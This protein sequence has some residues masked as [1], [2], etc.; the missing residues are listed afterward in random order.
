MSSL[1]ALALRIP[2]LLVQGQTPLFKV[3]S[4]IQGAKLS[5]SSPTPN[6]AKAFFVIVADLCHCDPSEQGNGLAA[7]EVLPRVPDEGRAQPWSTPATPGLLREPQLHHLQPGLRHSSTSGL[8]DAWGMTCTEKQQNSFKTCSLLNLLIILLWE[9]DAICTSLLQT[10]SL[11]PEIWAHTGATGTSPCRNGT[12]PPAHTTD[13][14]TALLLLQGASAS[15][16]VSHTSEQG[17]TGWGAQPGA[18]GPFSS[19]DTSV[20][21]TPAALQ[22]VQLSPPQNLP[23]THPA[24]RLRLGRGTSS[25]WCPVRASRLPLCQQQQQPAPCCSTAAPLKPSVQHLQQCPSWGSASIHQLSCSCSAWHSWAGQHAGLA[26][27][28]GQSTP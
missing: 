27:Q 24:W 8:S 3:I 20:S 2:S 13:T 1:G 23:G 12:I 6:S 22:A 28:Q 9:D 10:G 14:S 15:P 26:A 16:G 17:Q 25:P 7:G 11:S 19:W 5:D 4:V 18:A 21:S